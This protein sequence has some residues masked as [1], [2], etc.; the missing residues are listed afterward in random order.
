MF[1][2]YVELQQLKETAD[3]LAKM[4]D[5]TD[6][7]DEKQLTENEVPV[8]SITYVDDMYVNFD[9]ARDT[10]SKIK[11]CRHFVTNALY[12]NGYVI[13]KLRC[14]FGGVSSHLKAGFCL[15]LGIIA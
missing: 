12:H 1:D 9:L 7:Y 13:W 6:L 4:D 15:M 10:A 3:I 5:W 14:S 2:D 8:Y 11:N